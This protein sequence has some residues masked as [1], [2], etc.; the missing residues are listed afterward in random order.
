[1]SVQ[2]SFQQLYMAL[3]L[4]RFFKISFIEITLE[5]NNESVL[6]RLGVLIASEDDFPDVARTD[7]E[8]EMFGDE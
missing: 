6:S 7:E 8:L 3:L 1:M 2:M 4:V 5:E